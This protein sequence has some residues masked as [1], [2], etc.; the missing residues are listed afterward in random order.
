M[1]RLTEILNSGEQVDAL[2]LAVRALPGG[3]EAIDAA[4]DQVVSDRIS[5]RA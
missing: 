3:P 2:E 5:A 4:I 1:T